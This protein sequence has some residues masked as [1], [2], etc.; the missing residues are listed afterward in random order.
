LEIR[1]S[2]ISERGAKI[3]DKRSGSNG[4]KKTTRIFLKIILNLNFKF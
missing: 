2:T 3:D 1:S 4:E